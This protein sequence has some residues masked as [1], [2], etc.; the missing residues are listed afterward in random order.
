MR[1]VSPLLFGR[2]LPGDKVKNLPEDDHRR[3]D[4][5]FQEP[6]LGVHL[7]LVERLRPIAERNGRTLAQLAIA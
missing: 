6:E 4:P 2:G 1:L 5:M 3:K 7:K